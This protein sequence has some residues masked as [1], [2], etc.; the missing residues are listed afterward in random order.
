MPNAG[1]MSNTKL[2]AIMS[3][4]VSPVLIG[5]GKMELSHNMVLLI[6]FSKQALQ[7]KGL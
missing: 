3:H 6:I 7:S 5:T 4:A 2:D 1:I